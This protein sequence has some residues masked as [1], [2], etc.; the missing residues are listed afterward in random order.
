M[1]RAQDAQERPRY[2]CCNASRAAVHAL[3]RAIWVVARWCVAGPF[4]GVYYYW[5]AIKY[6]E[7]HTMPKIMHR[8]GVLLPEISG[9]YF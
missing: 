5:Q 6:M 2:E 3:D 8:Q 1:P 4:S 9:V 7:I